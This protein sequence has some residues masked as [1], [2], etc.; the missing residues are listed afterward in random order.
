MVIWLANYKQNGNLLYT[1]KNFGKMLNSQ[2]QGLLL[3]T[4]IH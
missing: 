3:T 1:K 2:K 4:A